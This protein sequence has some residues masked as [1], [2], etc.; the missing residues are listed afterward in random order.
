VAKGVGCMYSGDGCIFNFA[1]GA[2]GRKGRKEVEGRAERE[3]TAIV[4]ISQ[5]ASVLSGRE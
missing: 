4:G 1:D 2:V 3:A 5:E